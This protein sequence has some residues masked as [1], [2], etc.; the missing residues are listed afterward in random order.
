MSGAQLGLY[1]GVFFDGYHIV[2]VDG[3]A[4]VVPHQF[5]RIFDVAET[6][7]AEHVVLVKAEIF[8]AVH[9]EL[10]NGKAF[11]HELQGGVVVEGP[12]RDDDAARVDGEV[13]G[14]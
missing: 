9:V 10:Y 6:A 13:V 1:F 11:G 5:Y 3:L 7:L 2:D 8:G 4:L 12:L 14:E